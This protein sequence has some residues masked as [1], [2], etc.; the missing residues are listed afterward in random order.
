MKLKGGACT[1]AVCFASAL[2]II[3]LFAQSKE[4]F[5]S[6]KVPQHDAA[7]IIKL[8][9]VRVLDRG[10]RPVTDLKKED[11]VLYDNGK[12]KIITEFEVHTL[13]EEGMK[14]L[15]S[16]E[17]ADLARSV[18]GMN[19][20]L[21]I[22][23]DIQ[24]SDVNGMANAKQ[25]ALHFV[26]TQLRAGDE[27]GILAFSPMRGF[28]IQEYLTKD[29]EQIRQAIKKTKDI[30]IKPSPPFVV[31][32][33]GDDSV[34]DRSEHPGT[35]RSGEGS[36]AAVSVSGRADVTGSEGASIG[37]PGS[38]MFHQRDFVPRMFDLTQALKYVPGNKSL[39]IF[40]A[41][42]LGPNASRLGKEFAS[43][44]TP[45]Y[46]VNTQNWI[47]QGVFTSIKKKH[48]WTEHPLQDLARESGGKYFADIK[49]IETISREIQSLT[50]NYYV[51]G[52]YIDETWDGKYHQIKVE[53]AN[54][55]LQVL[56]QHGYF[57]PRPYAELSDFQKQIHLFDLVF[58][59]KNIS[60][61]L[62]E[63]PIEPLFIPGEEGANC[64][65][66][67][68]IA[69]DEKTGVPPSKVEI[70][71][72]LFDEDHKVV[73]ERNG[74]VDFSSFAGEILLPYFFADLPSGKYECRLVTR[75]TETGQASVGKVAFGIP[76]MSEAEIVLSSPL[77]FAAG[78]E[79]KIFKLSKK[80]GQKE[81]DEVLSLGVIY[82][83]LPEHH[84]LV[85]REIGPEIENLLAVLPVTF[86]RGP[87]QEVEFNVRLHPKPEGE[88]V[89]LPMEILDAKSVSSNKD[90][91]M[92]EMRLPDLAPGE[93][94]LEIEAVV[95][96]TSARFSVHRLLVKR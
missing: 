57:N 11:F 21:F 45:V 71:A 1:V 23:L 89:L 31:G 90:I 59:D 12:K 68:Q 49:D 7:A 37:A 3:T 69:V 84:S 66:L 9:M 87:A 64:V 32:A 5:Q 30:E 95:K 19:R 70:Y 79:S 6:Q 4:G 25:A 48:I 65:L 16:G 94:E 73:K 27:V 8:V 93:Y 61:E 54:P 80:K 53:V 46:T 75:D 43:A 34:R 14:V 39:I 81:K 18:E 29:H 2:F 33:G 82:W 56:A 62:L 47:R 74:D 35:M 51:L 86:S 24:G 72:L 92:M 83:D 13:S 55:G 22:F 88:A 28:L 38:S 78:P 15:P 60:A 17:A 85:V 10:G 76:D 63:I 41:R 52:Y 77:L 26:D 58:T 50:G 67:S 20:R 44:S 42:N 36:G 91:L 96:N 40:T